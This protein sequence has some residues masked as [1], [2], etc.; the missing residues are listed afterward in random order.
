MFTF[1]CVTFDVVSRA[2]DEGDILLVSL[3]AFVF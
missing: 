3:I 1:E 2:E